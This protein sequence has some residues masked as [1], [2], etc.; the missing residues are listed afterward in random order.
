MA[1]WVS[2]KADYVSGGVSYRELAEKHGVPLGSIKRHAATE[3]WAANRT[4]TEPKR[5]QKTVQKIIDRKSTR[6]ADRLS[7]L[8]S[9]GDKLAEKLEQ[10]TAELDRQLIRNKKKTRTITYGDEKAPGKP[11][12]EIIDEDE[13]LAVMP[14]PIDWLG[15]Q[16]LSSAL[17]N[18]HEV[19]KPYEEANNRDVEDVTP[20]AELLGEPHE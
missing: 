4:E 14:A 8:L 17:K 13:I 18:L 12:K 5:Y 10:A 16:Q 19:I 9:I 6:E 20:L 7:R 3:G 2:I 1:D 11:T 15:V